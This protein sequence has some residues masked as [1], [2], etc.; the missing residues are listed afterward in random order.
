MTTPTTAMQ[1][2][3]PGLPNA[4]GK[5]VYTEQD[6]EKVGTILQWLDD[7]KKSR[8]W[9]SKKANIPTGTLSQ[10]LTSK[11]VSSPTRQLTQLVSVLEVETDR[12]KDGTPG[13]VKGSVHKLLQVVFDRTRK[14]QNFGVVTG[15]VGVGKT[16]TGKEYAVSHPMTLFVEVSPNMTPGVLLTELLE[17]LDVAVPAGLDNKFREVIRVLRGTNY[18]LIADEAEKMSSSA[19]EYLRRIRDMA[20][21]GVVLTGTEKL[22]TLIKRQHGQFDQVRSRVGMWPKTIERIARDDADDIA[23]AALADAG[24]LSDEVLDEL[25]AYSAGSARVLTENLVPAIRDYGIGRAPISAE[26]VQKIAEKVLFMQRPRSE[27]GK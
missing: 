12:L 2:S 8:S 1:T 23:R 24:E 10:I 16:R 26:L 19:L 13:Y 11:Y 17:Q 25:W 14:H 5:A 22:T 27:G 21:V 18:L 7:N 3:L 6:N 9:L 15:Y 4:G 20:M